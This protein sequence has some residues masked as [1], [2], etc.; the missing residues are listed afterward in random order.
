MQY[1][2][3]LSDIEI[4]LRDLLRGQ[5]FYPALRRITVT[6]SSRHPCGWSAR[7]VGD[8]NSSE[9]AVC[10]IIVQALQAKHDLETEHHFYEY[11]P[12]EESVLESPLPRLASRVA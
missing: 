10:S 1:E 7:V 2:V 12:S 3:H 11:V 5:P 4:W 8:L 9:Q 6:R